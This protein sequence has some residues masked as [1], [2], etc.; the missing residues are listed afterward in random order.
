MS[1]STLALGF[2]AFAG[3]ASAILAADAVVRRFLRRR[4]LVHELSGDRAAPDR[5]LRDALARI[6]NAGVPSDPQEQ[7]EARARLAEAGWA[8]DDALPAF[9]GARL[10]TAAVLALPALAM[11]PT[12]G[13]QALAWAL[14][15]AAVG[16]LGPAIVVRLMR[17]HRRARIVEELPDLLDLVLVAMEGGLGFESAAERASGELE[18]VA[19]VFS[20]EL[21][22]ALREIR[23]GLS[24][25]RALD[26]LRE[27]CGVRAV[28]A[29]VTVLLQSQRYG[30]DVSE[31]LRVQAAA[32]RT[33]RRQAAQEKGARTPVRITFPMILFILPAL[34]IVVAGPGL[35][36]L[37]ERFQ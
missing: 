22:H 5:G 12:A 28:D 15:L 25:E 11:I 16:Y 2:V 37:M 17:D 9:Y 13:S 4:N 19:P 29:V 7:R 31:A 24:R 30:T 33:E 23:G 8:Q 26:H 36:R 35:I 32:L 18:H 21:R 3:G 1:A 6:G 14:A 34:L 27:R 10:L 20:A